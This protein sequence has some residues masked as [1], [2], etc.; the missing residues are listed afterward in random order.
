MLTIEQ[1]KELEQFDTPTVC[2]A[3]ERFGLGKSTEGYMLPGMTL[4]TKDHKPIVGYAVTAK[5]GGEHPIPAELKNENVMGYYATVRAVEAPTIAV[6]QDVEDDTYSSFWGEVQA[7]V[8]K[9]LGCVG[10]I[11]DGGV[12]D[13][14]DVN[15]VGFTLISTKICVSHGYTH[16]KE[17]NC[18]VSILGL[19]VCPGDLL[20]ADE[21]GVVIIPHEVA[22]ELAEA[23]R[24]AI[25]SELPLLNPC[26]EAIQNNVKPTMEELAVWRKE[27]AA[28]RDAK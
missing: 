26:R 7:T 17:Y 11:T 16:V 3:L 23:C 8:H 19:E 25:A 12:R 2:N 14:N 9:S 5:V 27:M 6:I 13:I 18:P 15:N 10:T 21:H 28:C 24:V 20:H 1:I 22:G 4:R